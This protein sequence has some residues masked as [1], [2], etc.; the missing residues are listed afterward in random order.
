MAPESASPRSGPIRWIAPSF[1]REIRR[2]IASDFALD[3]HPAG[4][5]VT[6]REG[7]LLLIRPGMAALRAGSA[8]S[9]WLH[10]TT[11]RGAW[12]GPCRELQDD[13]V[14]VGLAPAGKSSS[15][16]SAAVLARRCVCTVGLGLAVRAQAGP[17]QV[18]AWRRPAAAGA[19]EACA[20]CR[21]A[22]RS[23]ATA[24][25]S[26]ASFATSTNTA[27]WSSSPAVA[28]KASSRGGG[29]QPVPCRCGPGDAAVAAASRP[30]IAVCRLPQRPAGQ[31]VAG[32]VQ[33][34]S[35]GAGRVRS[36]CGV[37]ECA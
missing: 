18:A 19:A 2:Q 6:D 14:W 8:R 24:M 37:G 20:V 21:S 22:S 13:T 34:V 31:Y 4:V 3:R 17:A 26:S 33:G 1:D 28:T 25:A 35:S 30:G 12:P 7:Q 27:A 16:R 23:S 15:A 11:R 32:D 10:G 36:R 5:L 29:P 9:P